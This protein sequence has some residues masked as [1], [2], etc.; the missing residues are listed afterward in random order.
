MAM[1]LGGQLL[2]KPTTFKRIVDTNETDR[3]TLGGTLYTDF[4]NT[5]RSWEVSWKLLKAS[6]YTIINNLFYGQYSN[7][8]YYYLQFNAYSLYVPVKIEI[9]KNQNIRYNG[10][11][12]EGF[13]IILKEQY[14]IS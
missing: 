13:K 2:P 11:F 9:D 1:V 3:V 10:G 4:I 8:S 14:A 12:Y 7:E 6:D 5:R